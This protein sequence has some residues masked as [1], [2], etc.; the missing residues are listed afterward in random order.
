MKKRIYDSK[1][2]VYKKNF[3]NSNFNYI[4]TGRQMLDMGLVELPY[5]VD[6]IFPKTGLVAIAGSSDTGKSSLLRQFATSIVIGEPDFLGFKINAEHK[7]VIYVSTE[8]DMYSVAMLLNKQNPTNLSSEMYERLGYIFDTENL[9]SKLKAILSKHKVDCIII[10]AFSDLFSGEINSTSRVRSFLQVYSQIAEKY[11]C[12]IIFLHHTGK[13][14]EFQPP[15]KNNLLGSQ[16]FEAKMRLVIEL[17]RDPYNKDLRHLCIVK[18]NYLKDEYKD[19]SYKL[20][21]DEHMRF[22][23]LNQRVS[24]SNLYISCNKTN[25]DKNEEFIKKAKELKSAGK[26]IR[27]IAEIIT[28]MGYSVSKSTVSNWLNSDINT[29]V[30]PEFST[31]VSDEDEFDEETETPGNEEIE[32]E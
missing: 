5:L 19:S 28:K 21:F 27:E 23:N 17:R 18:G 24:F 11:K 20:K 1:N 2:I 15:S 30:Y 8:D 6:K 12:L 32:V 25:E 29:I 26:P 22:T 9:I 14:T 4:V 3:Q 13:K 10:D 16:G 7:R 31:Y